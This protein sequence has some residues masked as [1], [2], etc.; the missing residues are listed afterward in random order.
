MRRRSRAGHD[1][2]R[3]VIHDGSCG[4]FV[5]LDTL[6]FLSSVKVSHHDSEAA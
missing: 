4:G 3:T 5:L 6:V 2:E 1:F